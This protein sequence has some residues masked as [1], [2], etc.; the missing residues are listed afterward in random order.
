LTCVDAKASFRPIKD[1]GLWWGSSLFL[2]PTRPLRIN[3]TNSIYNATTIWLALPTSLNTNCAFYER[4]MVHSESST[5]EE[6]K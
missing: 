5:M 4:F 1:S 2:A 3:I 6:L